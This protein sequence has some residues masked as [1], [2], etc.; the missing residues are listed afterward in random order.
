GSGRYADHGR[1]L[2]AHEALRNGGCARRPRQRSD[3]ALPYALPLLVA[4]RDVRSRTGPAAR[5]RDPRREPRW[6][7]ASLRRLD[8]R[9]RPSA[10]ASGSPRCLATRRGVVPR[11]A[12]APAPAR[13]ERLRGGDRPQPLLATDARAGGDRA[14]RGSAGVRTAVP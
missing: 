3:V 14:P 7:A 1:P 5:A 10:R 11:A 8:D 13:P 12:A 4:S 9:R 2:A 6:R